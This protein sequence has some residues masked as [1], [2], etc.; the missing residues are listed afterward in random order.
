MIHNFISLL[1][2]DISQG[3]IHKWKQFLVS[4]LLFAFS[5]FVFTKHVNSFFAHNN[6]D[7]KTGIID[8][9]INMFI[10]NEPYEPETQQGIRLS[11]IWFVFHAFLF[12]FPGFYI[13]D[14]LK[15]NATAFILRVK[16]RRQW[17]E[18]KFIWC[19]LTV[20][21][22]YT[23]FFIVICLFSLL[24]GSFSLSANEQIAAEFFGLGISGVKA[25]DMLFVSFILPMMISIAIAVFEAA[26][27]LIVK[28]FYSFIIVICYLAASAFYCDVFLLF[29]FSML[30]RNSLFSGHSEITGKSGILISLGLIIISYLIGIFAV[31]KKNIL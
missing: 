5:A 26:L 18:S 6:I 22:Y 17:W 4:A 12:S 1:R 31:R 16:S 10:G 2:H 13:N 30:N 27:S 14:D 3:I 25:S 15:K 21:A 29:N 19:V 7:S 24:F 8:F 28:P 23:V 9:L 20:F 11:I